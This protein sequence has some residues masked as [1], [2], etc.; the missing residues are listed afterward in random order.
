MTMAHAGPMD[1]TSL[2]LETYVVN[3]RPK[4]ACAHVLLSPAPARKPDAT[5]SIRIP[6]IPGNLC[7]TPRV[8]ILFVLNSGWHLSA[9]YLLDKRRVPAWSRV[10]PSNHGHHGKVEF[11]YSGWA[12]LGLRRNEGVD[13]GSK[14]FRIHGPTCLRER[15]ASRNSQTEKYCVQGRGR[16]PDT[17][18]R[19]E[20]LC[21]LL[22]SLFC[23]L[24]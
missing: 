17:I 18:Y 16:P 1:R 7:Q 19:C 14:E 11:V 21:Y 6:L 22:K 13:G 2:K 4:T 5:N 23:V 20:R 9:H 24:L 10:L 15:S 3:H 12:P 8:P